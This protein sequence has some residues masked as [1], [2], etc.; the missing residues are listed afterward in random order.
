[1][2]EPEEGLKYLDILAF[3]RRAEDLGFEALY[4]SDHYTSV[5]DR[6]GLGSTDAWATLAGLARDT[7][8]IQLGTLVSPATFRPA[9]NLAKVVATITEMA[10]TVTGGRESRVHLGLGTG[11][12]ASEHAQYG[13]PFEDL[14]GR[15]RR[16]EEVLQVVRGL[17]DPTCEAFSFEGEFE[18]IEQ[19][20]FH[21]RPDPRPRIIVGGRGRDKTM[22]LAATYADELN[23]P[24]ATPEEC[25][26]VRTA[27]HAACEQ[28]GRDL[29]TITFSLMTGCMVGATQ[30][31]FRARTSRL[32]A[33]GGR[34]PKL[35]EYEQRLAIRGVVGTPEQAA[36]RLGKLAEVGVERVVLQH[37]FDDDL[38]LLDLVADIAS[39]L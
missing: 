24:S 8:Q 7:R 20:R 11:W 13:F 9:A 22:R 31:E 12:L 5:F 36:D 19:A 38:E 33:L 18:Q 23:T 10:G 32:E 35:A 14:G 6:E 2:I 28:Q 25:G 34:Y 29:S 26:R 27:L 39:R 21:P 17:W 4:R 15:F 30:R 16:L 37:L 1:M 3:A